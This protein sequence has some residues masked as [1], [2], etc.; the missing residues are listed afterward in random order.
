MIPQI[1]IGLFGATAIWFVGR[2]ESWRRWGYICGLCA[3]PFWYWTTI[4]HRQWGIC[5]M[6]VFYSYSWAQGV[7]NFWIQPRKD[8]A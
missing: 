7:W 5:A 2:R 8:N 6:S 4:E 3:Q 1:F